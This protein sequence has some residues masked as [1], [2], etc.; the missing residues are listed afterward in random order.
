MVAYQEGVVEHLERFGKA[1]RFVV[2]V[3]A[4]SPFVQVLAYS[5]GLAQAIIVDRT[6]SHETEESRRVVFEGTIRFLRRCGIDLHIVTFVMDQWAKIPLDR[7]GTEIL[8]ILSTAKKH[9]VHQ[10][11]LAFEK[12]TVSDRDSLR[13]IVSP[14]GYEIIRLRL[15]M[16]NSLEY[17]QWIEETKN[18]VYKKKPLTTDV[19]LNR[20][21]GNISGPITDAE[22]AHIQAELLRVGMVSTDIDWRDFKPLLQRSLDCALLLAKL[23]DDDPQ[24]IATFARKFR[25]LVT[26]NSHRIG[27]MNVRFDDL[28]RT[29]ERL[30]QLPAVSVTSL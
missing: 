12:L 14:I 6:V 1:G 8:P 17:L 3:N 24:G 21:T 10:L 9:L 7:Y 25:E 16:Y 15:T 13:R 19:N 18:D 5:P 29:I 27:G 23:V 28:L 22:F 26:D 30:R 20:E 11:M 2:F 4:H